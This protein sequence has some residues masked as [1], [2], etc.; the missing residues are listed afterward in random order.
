M[1]VL[2]YESVLDTF[3]TSTNGQMF[4]ALAEI[5]ELTI[6]S[7]KSFDVLLSKLVSQNAGGN[8]SLI[9]RQILSFSNE[10]VTLVTRDRNV[11]IPASAPVE[12]WCCSSD[13]DREKKKCYTIV[14]I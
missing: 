5:Y 2:L 3:I 6:L 8:V 10:N 9:V 7:S 4:A 13:N 14:Q 1:H 12:S 11:E